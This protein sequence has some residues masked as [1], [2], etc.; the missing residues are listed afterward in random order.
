MGQTPNKFKE[1]GEKWKRPMLRIQLQ[2]TH[3]ANNLSR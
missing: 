3:S 2:V 1:T